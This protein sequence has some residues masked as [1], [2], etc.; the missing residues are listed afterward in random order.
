MSA[1]LGWH[2]GDEVEFGV[3]VR[4]S[5]KYVTKRFSKWRTLSKRKQVQIYR[6]LVAEL[7]Q[8]KL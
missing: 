8:S 4:H 3:R 5:D 2:A 7:K 1:W 6:D